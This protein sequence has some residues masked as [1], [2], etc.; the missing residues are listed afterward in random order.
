MKT[1]PDDADFTAYALGE[2]SVEESAHVE[3]VIAESSEKRAEVEQTRELAAMLRDEFR[4]ELHEVK[5]SNIMPLSTK[6][7][8]WSD[9]RWSSLAIAAAVAIFAII[10]VLLLFENRTISS[11]IANALRANRI[12]RS[13]DVQIE[14]ENETEEETFFTALT[15][16]DSADENA[17]IPT[18]RNQLLQFP[19]NF[20]TAS[21]FAVRRSLEAGA[22]PTSD[23]IR[24][25]EIV[26]YFSSHSSAATGNEPFSIILE[27]AACPWQPAH[28]LLRIGVRV[29]DSKKLTEI[30]NASVEFN[31][32]YVAAYRLIGYDSPKTRRTEP[33]RSAA[34][35]PNQTA[36]ILF[37]VVP[38]ITR[39]SMSANSEMATVKLRYQRSTDAIPQEVTRA[40]RDEGGAF[41][42]ASADFRF[43]AAVAE[44]AMLLR[45]SS[46]DNG[47]R[48]AEILNWANAARGA[49][50]DEVRDEF[51][52]LVQQAKSLTNG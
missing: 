20:G 46:S 34:S 29:D 27:A 43:V 19:I 26:N 4:A 7:S 5:P 22:L 6:G 42:T 24:V 37:E 40:L 39:P 48:F 13:G 51:V 12:N 38:A 41:E 28:R 2:L 32:E 21:Y 8:F 30:E 36:T 16:R 9:A 18:S 17:F 49:E 31:P 52:R 23:A 15:P 10:G 14:V 50:P 25:E 35:S 3:K 47:G 1:N 11:R 45:T 33:E 44:F